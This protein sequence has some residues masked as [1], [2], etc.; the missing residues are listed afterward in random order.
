MNFTEFCQTLPFAIPY[1]LHHM[2][3]RILR[4]ITFWRRHRRQCW[5]FNASATNDIVS[6][7]FVQVFCDTW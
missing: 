2:E 7:E 3:M 6:N 5:S 1:V 4:C